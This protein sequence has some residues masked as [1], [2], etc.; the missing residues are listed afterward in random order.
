MGKKSTPQQS[1]FGLGDRSKFILYNSMGMIQA[2]YLV[3]RFNL[4]HPGQETL[5]KSTTS[6]RIT[7]RL[8]LVLEEPLLQD[9]TDQVF[10][11]CHTK[12]IKDLSSKLQILG[13]PEKADATIYKYQKLSPS[14]YEAL[15]EVPVAQ[16]DISVFAFAK[17]QLMRGNFNQAKYA[18]VSSF[19]ATLINQHIK[20]L[21]YPEWVKL[22]QDLDEVIFHPDCLKNHEILP[23]LTANSRISLVELI[24]FLEEHQHSIILNIRDLQEKYTYCGLKRIFGERDPEDNLTEP[25]LKT[26]FLDGGEYVQMGGFE[27][28]RN[29]ATINLLI[30]RPVQLVPMNQETA[31]AEVA[32][33]L[34][35]N[36]KTYKNY[37]LVSDGELKIKS[38]RIKLSQKK[39]FNFLKAKGVIKPAE[40][41]NFQQEY[42]L[43]LED[44]PLVRHEVYDADLEGVFTELAEIQVLSSLLAAHL[45]AESEIYTSEQMEVFKEHYLSQNL[46][47]NFPTTTAYPD[48]ET[49]LQEGLVDR[50]M[51]HKIE[52]GDRHILNLNKFPSA[53]KFLNRLYEVYDR[54]TGE[55]I[56][57]PTF[58]QM[59]DR[60]VIIGHK[61]LSKRFKLTQVDEFMQA[62]FDNFFG[63]CYN[64]KIAQILAKVNCD[65]L[66]FLLQQKWSGKPLEKQE[67]L[68]A[69][70]EANRQLQAYAKHL[71]REKVSPLVFYIGATGLIPGDF[72][73]VAQTADEL[74]RKYDN[75]TFSKDEQMGIFFEIGNTI[76]GI[77]AKTE[78]YSTSSLS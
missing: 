77:Y 50:R 31:I 54:L 15:A 33:V 35:T 60:E 47:L 14:D 13:L 11:S 30:S 22:G 24:R 70:T 74:S 51:S 18:L 10:V 34:L 2:Y 44:L 58:A 67:L 4:T 38:L 42:T 61:T 29:T 63:L 43:F 12:T 32:G 40:Q 45:K 3:N 53:N 64:Y 26:K 57:N 49:A 59:L 6:S 21:T 75:L 55:R 25:E 62:I 71:Y 20:A 69:M 9:Y 5:A 41:F 19:D 48:L 56:E 27:F 37:T 68:E 28:N 7:E 46:Y 17:A 76:L 39:V 36:L 1:V 52:I 8:L 16:T 66:L 65:R 78:Y 72:P 23:S 73:A